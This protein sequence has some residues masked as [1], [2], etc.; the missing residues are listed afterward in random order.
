MITNY[1]TLHA[2]VEEWGSRI[3]G[4]HLVDAF[5]QEKG[6]LTLA[7]ASASTEIMV[8]LSVRAPMPYVFRVDGYSRARRNVATLFEAALDQP[9]TGLHI[10]DRDRMIY[11]DLANGM[12]L[13]IMLFGP[14]ANVFLVRP[15]GTVHEAF[16]N[17]EAHEGEPPPEPR[18]A[19]VVSD[20]ATFNDRWRSSR[21]SLEHALSSAFPLFD[22]AVAREA[23]LRA[24]LSPDASPGISDEDAKLL[25]QSAKKIEVELHDPRPAIYWE[26]KDPIQFSLIPLSYLPDARE[27]R[28]ETVDEAAALYV[29]SALG[30]KQFES[31]F[32]PVEKALLNAVEH[33]RTSAE[34]MMDELVRESRA[35]R[36]E[37]YGH[38]LMAH[39]G[40][41]PAGAEQVELENLFSDSEPITIELDPARSAVENA[42]AYYD[43]ARRTRRSREEAEKRLV[44]TDA[45]GKQ[46]EML[47]EELRRV[48]GLKEI[49][50]FR[51]ER[52]SELA[53][54]LHDDESPEQRIPF[55]RFRLDGGYEV[56]VGRNA[57]QNDELTF[58]HAQKYDLWMHARGV[59]GSHVILR[60]PNRNAQP[61]Q[62]IIHQAAAVAAY[63]SKARGSSL[64]PVMVAER[65]FVRKPK[66]AGPGAVLVEREDVV[67]AEPKL[68]SG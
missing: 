8:R 63:F 42:Q 67:L 58:R 31:L 27:E 40:Q 30:Q 28:F 55:R 59:A 62:T 4:L 11:F 64:V 34:R 60:L 13:Q 10:A 65:K 23:V 41:V 35:D 56:W 66:G 6:E 15:D 51:K 20:L 19:A 17:S 68:P 16:Q 37:T 43:R 1:Y 14:R 18:A 2:L 50:N 3:P 7:F 29:K 26:G 54:Y 9:V 36:Y 22:R 49:R 38:L 45:L 12:R 53:R 39:A 52:S 57:R 5:S 48:E 44:E 47:L 46:A 33:Y 24:G 61:G 32:R 21:K 25:Y